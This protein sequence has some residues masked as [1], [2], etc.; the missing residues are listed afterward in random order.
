MN[1]KLKIGILVDSN[2]IPAWSFH[3]IEKIILSNHAEIKLIIKKT[4]SSVEIKKS[5]LKKIIENKNKILYIAYRKFDAKIFKI[6]KDAFTIKSLHDLID[7]EEI[8]IETIETK[9]SDRVNEKDLEKIKSQNLDV[10]IRL[11]FKILRG[12]ILKASNYG[13]WSYHHG[14][15]KINR[16]G[17]AGVW[18]V[19]QNWEE[20]GVT[21]QILNEDL[22]AG[23]VLG[24]SSISTD[25]IS[26]NRNLNEL[27][28]SAASLLPRKISEL[29]FLGGDE[30]LLNHNKVN[31][32]P[33][34]YDRNL[35]KTPSNLAVSKFVLRTIYKRSSNI[36]RNFFYRDQWI[37]LFNLNTTEKISTTFNKFKKIVPPIDRFWADPFIL[38]KN[39]YY[40]IFI[41]EL[42]YSTKKGHISVIKMDK[43]G[44]YD[45]PKT[46]LIR[47][48]HLSYPFII[49]DNNNL[50]MI[51]E[52]K[53]N[54]TIELY[55]CIEFPLKWELEKVLMTNISAVDTT[56]L[57]KNNTFW[58]FTNI[59]ENEGAS[60]QNELFLYSSDTLISDRWAAY[61]HNP[62]ISD[63]KS[64]RPAG[65]FFFHNDQLYRPSQNCAKTYGH[66]LV[67]NK[68]VA[69]D[70]E[71]YKEIINQ[72]I[73][74]EW[75]KDFKRI[76]TLNYSGKLTVID[77][78]NRRRKF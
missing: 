46:V 16:G 75:N 19:F 8:E 41:E 74:S 9:F 17:P 20:T 60:S 76:H 78:I 53:G 39:G 40:Y 55:K 73:Y 59:M 61:S 29:Y 22:D 6:P 50:Y 15:N 58:M 47:D 14:D 4:N 23:K 38:E 11:G 56:I 24:Y 2:S 28:W 54:K 44:N 34:F 1:N 21:L 31:S 25:H 7:C 33:F 42:F 77:V 36:L 57:K 69:F 51:P 52:T 37:I 43:N 71:N 12:G 70:E 27:Y 30:F 63:V 67:I 3:M 64:A 45:Q 68:V 10:I 5:R 62:I 26:V 32:A 48:Y 65:N 72:N 18:E 66:G 13:I 35:Y 49:E